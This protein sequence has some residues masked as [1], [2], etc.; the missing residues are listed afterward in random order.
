MRTSSPRSCRRNLG[1][2]A[3]ERL[4][5]QEHARPL[6]QRLRDRDA[7][8]LA[9]AHHVDAALQ[10]FADA[11]ELGR[12]R[13]AVVDRRL[14]HL[15]QPQREGDVLVDV[16]VRI[17]PDRLEHHR[18]V[19]ALGRNVGDVLRTE[20]YP[21]GARHL[22]A[23][24]DVERRRLPAPGRPQQHQQLLRPDLEIEPS[25]NLDAADGLADLLQADTVMAEFRGGRRCDVGGHRT[26][27]PLSSAYPC[28][29]R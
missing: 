27:L 10:Q 20:E 4:I 9:A 23:G 6:D 11:E 19:A 12:D 18:H 1:V 14:R 16:E 22:D 8:T 2:E 26:P 28:L 25:K 15:P 21:P 29:A 24:D 17:E 3:A 13:D 5:Q 7:L